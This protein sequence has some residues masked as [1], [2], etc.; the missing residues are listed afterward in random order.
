MRGNFFSRILDHVNQGLYL[1]IN[2]FYLKWD[3]KENRTKYATK[4]ELNLY[5]EEIR[6][7][8]TSGKSE[9]KSLTVSVL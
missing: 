2:N 6:G 3:V 5:S 4:N 7:F 8:I 1:T 9:Q